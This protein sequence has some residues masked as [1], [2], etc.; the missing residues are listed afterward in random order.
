M[1]FAGGVGLQQRVVYSCFELS[2]CDLEDTDTPG[3]LPHFL[4][5]AMMHSVQRDAG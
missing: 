4:D 5:Q 1:R 3:I 2:L